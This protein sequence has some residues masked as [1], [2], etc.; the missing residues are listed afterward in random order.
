[1]SRKRR[2]WTPQEK[3]E[4]VL[5]ILREENTLSELSRKYEIAQ[6][7]LSRWKIEFLSNMSVVFD[8]KGEDID[9]LKQEHE[10]EKEH[11]VKK[12]GELTMDVDWL[13]KKPQTSIRNEEKKALIDFKNSNLTV[14]HQ[15]ELIDLPRST[16]YH[17]VIEPEPE[18]SQA[19][20][21]I[22]NA[23]DR[24]HY[25][26]AS[27]GVRRIRNEL[28]NLGYNIGRRLVKRYMDEMDIV[29]FY[30]GP[31]LSKRAKMAKTY[32]YLLRNMKISKPNQVWSIDIS[33]VGTPTGFV[34]LTAIIDWYSRFIVGYSISNT[35]QTDTVTR[36]VKDAVRKHGMPEII[37][38]DQGSQFTSNAY[39]DLI[40]SYNYTKISMDGKG[41]ATDNIAIERFFRSYKWERLYLEYPETVTE[42]KILTKKYIEHYNF[43]RGHQS[44]DYKTPAEIYYDISQ[45]AA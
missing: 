15:C 40:K 21:D 16:A 8:K 10:E 22:K 26:E 20:I 33:Y 44:Y 3:V 31:N 5:E 28:K 32:P 6:P 43:T 14:K 27:Y 45:Q 11:L 35:L 42:V 2:T 9:K 25:K 23:I 7:I 1:M 30:P 37:N 18:P 29:A 41:R 39:I 13:K 17:T 36:V 34:Y 38:S 24:I 19:E 12:I 4:I